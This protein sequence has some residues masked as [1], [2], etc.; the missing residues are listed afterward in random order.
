VEALLSIRDML[1]VGVTLFFALSGFLITGI[2][3]DTLGARNYFR[4]FFAR[5]AVRIF[6][7]YYGVLLVLLL[8]TRPLHLDWQG[9]AYR[10]WT[11]TPNIPF[12]ND[13]TQNP[14]RYI[15]L[16]HFWSLAVEEQFYLLW[17]LLVFW[18][19]SWR[20]IF[21]ATLIGSALALAFRT[22][23]VVAGMGPQ[24][25]ALPFCMD[26]LLLGGALALLVRSK[27]REAALRWGLPVFLAAAAVT[28]FET[29]T[30][31]HFNWYTSAYLTTVGMTV[32]AVGAAGL[33]AASL[34]PASAANLFFSQGFLR[35]FGR[36]SY[37]LYVYHYSI[38]A[39]L[40]EPLHLWF[41]AHGLPKPLA[42]V[43]SALVTGSL[44][45]VLAVLSYHLYEKRF[46]GLKR[47]FP[48]RKKI[49]TA[50]L[51]QV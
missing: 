13:W 8:L 12:H 46:L 35:F 51:A 10:L 26:G 5:R 20:R 27:Y 11:Y 1:W 45:V 38:D 33:I 30:H 29:V 41:I 21:A 47:F 50:E 9:Q 44:S 22:G 28:L 6:P 39:S 3:Y 14:S 37:G 49:E 40:T 24:N 42:I 2:L 7:L 16:W 15:N 31:P 32:I 19:H 25:H 48:Y 43:V 18:L 36:Y 17:P 4:T 34:V 23:L